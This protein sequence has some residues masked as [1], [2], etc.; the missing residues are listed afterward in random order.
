MKRGS[1]GIQVLESYFYQSN[2]YQETHIQ[3]Q[4]LLQS[5]KSVCQIIMIGN[6]ALQV[7]LNAHTQHYF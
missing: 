2:F 4:Q 1:A 3:H 7:L 5:S 6:S